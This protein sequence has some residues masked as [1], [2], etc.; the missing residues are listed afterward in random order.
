MVV[1]EM[2]TRVAAN[3]EDAAFPGGNE[4]DTKCAKGTATD[5]KAMTI[6]QRRGGG[7]IACL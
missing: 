4:Q 3:I 1:V 2:L 6:R 7:N 5:S